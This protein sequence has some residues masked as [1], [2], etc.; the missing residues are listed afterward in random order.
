MQGRAGLPMH[1]G[2]LLETVFLPSSQSLATHVGG[3]GWH[4]FTCND[5]T[6][7]V[8]LYIFLR[9]K[10]TPIAVFDVSEAS[11]ENEATSRSGF[12]T[13]LRAIACDGFGFNGNC[14]FYFIGQ[15][16]CVLHRSLQA[17]SLSNTI[18]M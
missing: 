10:R 4:L 5:S 12:G 2:N 7:F 13:V 16:Y 17:T 18:L 9:V 3:S 6:I 11:Y 14:A 1:Y 15:Y 8:I